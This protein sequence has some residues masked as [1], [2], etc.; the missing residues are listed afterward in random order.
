RTTLCQPTTAPEPVRSAVAY[1]S[2]NRPS[3]SV[4]A[5]DEGPFVPRFASGWNST[6]TF[7]ASSPFTFTWPLTVPNGGPE[8]QPERT[9]PVTVTQ[10]RQAR[11]SPIPVMNQLRGG[12]PER[13][14]A[15]TPSLRREGGDGSSDCGSNTVGRDWFVPVAGRQRGQRLQGDAVADEADRA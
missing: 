6:R 5:V 4:S 13:V 9:T 3:S 8:E 10:K 12:K 1:L 14:R 7:P 15:I 2:W 11:R